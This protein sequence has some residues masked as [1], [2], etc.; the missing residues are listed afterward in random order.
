MCWHFS[1]LCA[2][3]IDPVTEVSV[4]VTSS[5]VLTTNDSVWTLEVG[6][7]QKLLHTPVVC[8]WRW[9]WWPLN[10]KWVSGIAV[11]WALI[12][13]SFLGCLS[14]NDCFLCRDLKIPCGFDDCFCNITAEFGGVSNKLSRAVVIL[15]RK[16]INF[17]T[18][19]FCCLLCGI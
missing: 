13:Q 17:F 14:G 7:T 2:F 1:V 6:T 5:V 4:L 3:A 18:W 10:T 15:E 12:T 9:W 19:E 11:N 16:K 8:D